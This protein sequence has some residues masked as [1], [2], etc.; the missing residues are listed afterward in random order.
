MTAPSAKLSSGHGAPRSKRR[1]G[2]HTMIIHPERPRRPPV[3]HGPH[4][5]RLDGRHHHRAPWNRSRRRPA[6]GQHTCRQQRRPVTTRTSP[7]A[8]VSREPRAARPTNYPG[9]RVNHGGLSGDPGQQARK[10]RILTGVLKAQEATLRPGPGAR[11]SHR[12]LSHSRMASRAARPHPST[13]AAAPAAASAARRAGTSHRHPAASMPRPASRPQPPSGSDP[14]QQQPAPQRQNSTSA[15]P[16]TGMRRLSL[17]FQGRASGTPDA[18]GSARAQRGRA[19]SDR[20]GK[21]E[22]RRG[23]PSGRWRRRRKSGDCPRPGRRL[24]PR[25]LGRKP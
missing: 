15:R 23:A 11:L 20:A 2:Q 25:P 21:R 12:L 24:R 14:S 9:T 22:L 6:H 5:S 7:A 13:P 8:Q 18:P 17:R 19:R 3:H 10:P 1:H 4:G 16:P